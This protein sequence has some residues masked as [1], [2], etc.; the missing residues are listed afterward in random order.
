SKVPED[1]RILEKDNM[2]KSIFNIEPNRKTTLEI[3]PCTMKACNG[4]HVPLVV[5]DEIDTVSGE[6]LKA[7]KEISGMLDSRGDQ[8][9]L[10]VGISTRKSRYGLMNQQ[11]EN[12]ESAGRTVRRWTAFEFS[13]RCPD[14]RSGTD[15]VELY[16]KQDEMEVLTK[17]KWEKQPPQ[18]KSE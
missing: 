17:D 8:K 12:A 5:V 10:R 13:A 1:K 7:F 6:A 11:I 16:V 18:R 3:L 14:S 4:P 2:T 15:P 9:A